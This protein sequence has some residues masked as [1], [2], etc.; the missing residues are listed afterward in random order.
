MVDDMGWSDLGCFGSEIG[1]PNLDRLATEGTR[2]T[3]LCNT[4]RCCPSRAALLT[5]VYPHQADVGHM[6]NHL[7]H[8]AYQGH[9][10]QRPTLAETLRNSGY[11]TSMSGK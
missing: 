6:L 5:G 7:G 9:L 4:D 8:P 1:T 3:Q 11:A 2:D 10:N